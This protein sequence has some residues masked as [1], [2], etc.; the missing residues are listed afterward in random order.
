MKI[1]KQRYC[2][3]YTQVSKQARV[4]EVLKE[5]LPIERG[6]VF[7]PCMECY[8]RDRG[9]IEIRPIF[10]GY[11]FIRSDMNAVELHRYISEN[12]PRLFAYVYELGLRRNMETGRV[13]RKRT[14][15][16]VRE[17]ST[18]S[19]EA[20]ADRKDGP[21][22]EEDDC[23][24]YELKDL[25]EDESRFMDFLLGYVASDNSST[26]GDYEDFC[27]AEE[28]EEDAF[29]SERGYADGLLRMS[30][31]YKENG[32]YVVMEGPL[33]VYEDKIFDVNRHE[34]KAFL[35]FT[36]NGYIVRAGLELKPKEYWF[37]KDSKEQG[38]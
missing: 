24:E 6:T 27:E 22:Q 16:G 26:D 25:T 38:Q 10:P 29:S 1:K 21:E 7:Y 37:P 36:V 35:D 34:R 2:V 12:K 3:L 11:V 32:K 13:R 19:A 8:R 20:P 28:Y 14:D 33:K 5:A 18:G 4:T 31:G 15:G 30:Y 9:Q 17:C 23:E